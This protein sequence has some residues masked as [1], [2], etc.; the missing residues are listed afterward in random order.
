MK[1]FVSLLKMA[2]VLPIFGFTNLSNDSGLP[3]WE[4]DLKFSEAPIVC[5]QQKTPHNLEEFDQESI[6]QFCYAALLLC[7]SVASTIGKDS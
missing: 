7:K 3:E 5:K 2:V 1:L 6:F 4:Q